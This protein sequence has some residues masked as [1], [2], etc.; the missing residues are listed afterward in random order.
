MY[1]TLVCDTVNEYTIEEAIE[2]IKNCDKTLISESHHFNLRNRKRNDNPSL[3]YDTFLNEAIKGII[4]QDLNK[5]KVIFEH[6]TISS[7][8]IVIIF[9]IEDDGKSVKFITTFNAPRTKR[10]K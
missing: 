1:C 8:D 7:K 4:K 3:V 2:V 5:F 9:I 6:K 10:E